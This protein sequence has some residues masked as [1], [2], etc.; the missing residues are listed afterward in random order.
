MMEGQREL[1]VPVPDPDPDLTPVIPVSQKHITP[2]RGVKG[3]KKG[4]K[5]VPDK[6]RIS[7]VVVTSE[8]T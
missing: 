3:V 6:A 2:S 5:K 1:R 8:T 4:V 7:S